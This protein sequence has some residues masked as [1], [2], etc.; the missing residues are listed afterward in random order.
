M[1]NRPIVKHNIQK[2]ESLRQAIAKPGKTTSAPLAQRWNS[3]PN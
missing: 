1:N 2:F 3:R